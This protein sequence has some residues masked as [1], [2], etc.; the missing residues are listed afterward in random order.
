MERGAALLAQ[1]SRR[2]ASS[3]L[4][5]YEMRAYSF[6]STTSVSRAESRGLPQGTSAT[7]VSSKISC[8]RRSL[9]AGV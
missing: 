1:D 6:V 8:T 5:A 9:S 2:A 7:G 4:M 3:G